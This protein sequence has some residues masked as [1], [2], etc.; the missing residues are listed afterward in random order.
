MLRLLAGCLLFAGFAWGAGPACEVTDSGS[1]VAPRFDKGYIFGWNDPALNQ[2]TLY[3]PNGE[4]LYQVVINPP[5][6]RRTLVMSAAVDTDGM[7]AVSYQEFPFKGTEYG[8][9]ALF[10]TTGMAIRYINTGAYFATHICFAPDHSIWTMGEKLLHRSENYL[11]FRNFSRGGQQLGAFVPRSS[12]PAWEGAGLDQELGPVIGRSSLIHAAKDRIGTLLSP[13]P[14]KKEWIELDYSGNIRGKWDFV[15]TL[16][17]SW[18]PIA[19]LS[20][21]TLYANVWKRHQFTGIAVLDTASGKWK[22]VRTGQR[23]NLAGADGDELAYGLGG[24]RYL[25]ARP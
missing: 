15:D 17:K 5:N 16:D 2:N 18:Q 20:D 4:K 24:Y 7:L 12:L 10:D 22:P 14:F 25:W 8:A 19:F 1:L 9:I 6:S 21:G 13:S 11:A 3:G 23:G